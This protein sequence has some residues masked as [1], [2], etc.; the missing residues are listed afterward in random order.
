MQVTVPDPSICSP[1]YPDPVRY[2]ARIAGLVLITVGVPAIAIAVG[3]RLGALGGIVF[4]VIGNL[5]FRYWLPRSAHGA[6]DAGRLGAARRRYRLLHRTATSAS[7][8]RAAHLSLIGCLVA[9]GKHGE[10]DA[11]ATKIDL[12]ALDLGERAVLLNNRACALLAKDAAAALALID[13]AT[14]F[15]PDVPAL[16]HTRAMALLAVGRTDDAIG[17]LD[18]MRTGGELP[19]RLEAERCRDLARAWEQKGQPA[20]AEDYRMRADALSR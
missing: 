6:F 13:E 10:A 4:A 17:I 5:W 3:G 9:E 16:Q 15:R 7:R 1:R 20:Y 14:G 8:E 2:A 19:P 18:G 11:L 12:A